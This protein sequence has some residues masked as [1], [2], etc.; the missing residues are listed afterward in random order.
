VMGYDTMPLVTMEQKEELLKQVL[1]ERWLMFFEHDPEIA[2]G[3]LSMEAGR[4]AVKSAA[5]L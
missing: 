3:Y 4:Y 5:A 2:A 1:N